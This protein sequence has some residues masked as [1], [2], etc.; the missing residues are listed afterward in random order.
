MFPDRL[1]SLIIAN[2]SK[3]GFCL[4]ASERKKKLA[5]LAAR[6]SKLERDEEN[7]IERLESNGHFVLRRGDANPYAVLGM[8]EIHD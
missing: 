6:L 3:L 1:E 4:S 8:E 2:V 7:E 5:S